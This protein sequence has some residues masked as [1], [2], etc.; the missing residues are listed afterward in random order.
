MLLLLLLGGVSWAV[1]LLNKVFVV[2]LLLGVGEH[3]SGFSNKRG[4]REP[5]TAEAKGGN[6]GCG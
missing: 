2:F 6:V 4:Y 5:Q 3:Y 1:D